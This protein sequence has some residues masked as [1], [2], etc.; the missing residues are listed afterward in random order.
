M[1]P[2]TELLDFLSLG[3]KLY[4]IRNRLCGLHKMQGLLKSTTAFL[5]LVSHLKTVVPRLGHHFHHLSNELTDVNTDFGDRK[6][7]V[8]RHLTFVRPD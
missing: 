4:S 3:R 6:T 5:G 7:T 2:F 1:T 8:V